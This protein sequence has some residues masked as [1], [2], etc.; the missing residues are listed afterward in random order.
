MGSSRRAGTGL[1]EIIPHPLRM[2]AGRLEL[3][4]GE[5]GTRQPGLGIRS[6]ALHTELSELPAGGFEVHPCRGEIFSALLRQPQVRLADCQPVAVAETGQ[7]L[8]CLVQMH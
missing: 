7:E 6:V 2:L 5:A 3:A 1:C 4:G 8:A